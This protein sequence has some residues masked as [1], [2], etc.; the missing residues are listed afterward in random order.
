MDAIAESKALG[1]VA[2]LV[3][4]IESPGIGPVQMVV[5]GPPGLTEMPDETGSMPLPSLLAQPYGD[6]EE[7]S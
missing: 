5:T 1:L 7:L 3:D 2:Y 6:W 4:T